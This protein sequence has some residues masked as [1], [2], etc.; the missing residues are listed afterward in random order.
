MQSPWIVL[1]TLLLLTGPPAGAG[2]NPQP[3]ADSLTLSQCLV[4]LIEEARVPAQEAGILVELAAKEGQQVK[5]GELLARIDD[6]QIVLAEKVTGLKLNAAQ[7]KAAND[8]DVRYAK[9]AADVSKA[10]YFQ[11]VR[12]TW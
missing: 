2:E 5:A 3:P 4:S 8:V 12:L 6:A 9:A 11:A 10:E 1:S 7:E